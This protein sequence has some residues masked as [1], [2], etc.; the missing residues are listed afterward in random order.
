MATAA[1]HLLVACSFFSAATL[2]LLTA[3]QV[4]G[5]GLHVDPEDIY[6]TIQVIGISI[7][8]SHLLESITIAEF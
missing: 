3:Q 4:H 8:L 5:G 1:T 2:L 7:A 6:K